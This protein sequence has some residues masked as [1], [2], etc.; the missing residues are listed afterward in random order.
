MQREDSLG[1]M[2]ETFRRVSK[3]TVV[4]ALAIFVLGERS[5]RA[6]LY[7]ALV[8]WNTAVVYTSNPE[9]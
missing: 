7:D 1:G 8:S 6:Y 2:A 9:S 5:P 4:A 3:R